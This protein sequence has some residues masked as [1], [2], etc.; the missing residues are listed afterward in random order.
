V[1]VGEHL[2]LDVSRPVQ[3]ALDE[4]LAT[5]ERGH[6]LAGRRLQQVG[7][8]LERAGDLQAAP[9]A[10]KRG[11]DRH[12]QAVLLG[13]CDDLVRPP[14]RLGRTGYEGRAGPLRDVPG[15]H[16][17]PE[18]AD[19]LRRGAD[20]G[21]TRLEHRLGEVGVLGEESVPGVDRVGG[22]PG[23]HVEELVDAQVGLGRGVAVQCER[24]VGE[25]RVHR[26]AVGIR[27]D[28]DAVQAGVAAGADHSHGDF[29]AVGD[30]HLAHS[31]SSRRLLTG[32]YPALIGNGR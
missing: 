29:P 5:P 30:E 25:S 7:D 22:G 21:E 6:G 8:L 15:G 13:E 18:V 20:P 11:L 26:V 4:A 2:R 32:M 23:R 27:V 12:G 9:A 28:G 10:T 17:V 14:H 24:L 3:V 31:G 16:L 19:G 1:L